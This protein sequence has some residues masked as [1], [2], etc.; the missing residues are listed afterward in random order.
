MRSLSSVHVWEYWVH[1]HADFQP[2]ALQVT[3]MITLYP[4]LQVTIM[5][6]L[7]PALRGSEKDVQKK[8]SN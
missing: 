2:P 1:S 8:T 3:I 5:T 7:Y 4:A 6:T